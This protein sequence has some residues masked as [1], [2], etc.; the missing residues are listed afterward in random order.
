MSRLSESKG[1]VNQSERKFSGNRFGDQ[2]IM[3][4]FIIMIVE[5]AKE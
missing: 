3:V 4:E 1:F 5:L 2:T